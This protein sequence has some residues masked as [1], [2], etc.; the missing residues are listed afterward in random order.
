MCASAAL[1]VP[2][3]TKPRSRK[4]PMADV[5]LTTDPLPR[6][7]QMGERGLGQRE[8]GASR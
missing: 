6:V 8:R 2:Y 1:A 4:R 3:A 5:M 7:E